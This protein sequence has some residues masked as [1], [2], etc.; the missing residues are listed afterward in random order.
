MPETTAYIL[1]TSGSTGQPKGVVQNHG[2]LLHHIR[3]YTNSLHISQDDRLTLLSSY[4]FDA[5]VMDIFGAL[6]NGATVCL[7]NVREEGLDRL[8]AWLVRQEITIYHSTPTVYRCLVSSLTG[9]EQFPRIRMVVL[10]GEDVCRRDVDLYRRYFSDH[11]LLVNGLGPTESTLAL[12]HVMNAQ[13]VIVGN[14][15]PVGFPVE[16]TEVSL[17]NGAGEEVAVYAIGEIQICSAHLA[18]GYW[19]QPELTD[20]AFRPAAGDGKRRTYRTGDLG[21]RLPDGSIEFVG[22]KDGQVKIRGHRVE[23]EEI[24]T[25]ILEHDGVKAAVV[26]VSE[27]SAGERR[28]LA[29]VVPGEGHT[30]SAS[31]LHRALSERLPAYMLPSAFVWL[32]SMPMLPNGKVDRR[33]LPPLAWTGQKPTRALCRP[34]PPRRWHWRRSGPSSWA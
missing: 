6:L 17:L 18:T 15:V 1:Y 29:Y 10:G 26:A 20:A 11:C 25:Q 7:F 22:R 31:A 30:L 12:Q 4:S 19:Q 2:N 23:L 3:T 9:Q 32:A 33:A 14:R 5:A 24:E 27:E 16:D 21:R 28:L 8:A 34:A 13:S